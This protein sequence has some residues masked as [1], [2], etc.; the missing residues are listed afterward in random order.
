[1]PALVPQL[2][3]GLTGDQEVAGSTPIGSATF[4]CGDWPWNIFY[5]HSLPCADSRRAVVR[6]GKRIC[7]IL[8][9][10]WLGKLTM[11]NMTPFGW[12]HCKTSTRHKQTNHYFIGDWKDILNDPYL[13]PDPVLWLNLSGLNYPCL[14]QI[15]LVWKMFQPLVWLYICPQP[16]DPEYWDTLT[17]EDLLR[18]STRW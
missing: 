5:G 13:P 1:M 18:R 8:V 12:L 11:L 3:A 7:T 15:S 4:F 16:S 6:S 17:P 2:D 10:V 14:E 9:I